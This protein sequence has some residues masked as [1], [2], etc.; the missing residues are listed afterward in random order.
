MLPRILSALL[1]F[2]LLAAVRTYPQEQRPKPPK[3][4]E[5]SQDHLVL[6]Q[7]D[8]WKPAAENT[9]IA[10]TYQQE[11][12]LG[13][14]A[15]M[16]SVNLSCSFAF[17][18]RTVELCGTGKAKIIG[19]VRGKKILSG[20]DKFRTDFCD[21]FA[22]ISERVDLSAYNDEDKLKCKLVVK[23]KAKLSTDAYVEVKARAEVSVFARIASEK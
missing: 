10:K 7:I 21:S 9:K 1:V 5:E 4:F 8:Q 15:G 12:R 19:K 23:D 11:V 18:D 2:S 14:M 17:Y 13:Q 20:T 6:E 3:G 22:A 16:S